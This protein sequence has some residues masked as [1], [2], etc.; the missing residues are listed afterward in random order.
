MSIEPQN[1]N[2]LSVV[3]VETFNQFTHQKKE[4]KEKYCDITVSYQVKRKPYSHS[5]VKNAQKS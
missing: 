2:L 1:Q 3:P 5:S 4:K